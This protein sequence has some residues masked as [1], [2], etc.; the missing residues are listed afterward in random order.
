MRYELLMTDGD[1]P[2]PIRGSL[3][4]DLIFPPEQHVPLT[5]ETGD[6]ISWFY[7]CGKPSKVSEDGEADEGYF[8]ESRLPYRF[9]ADFPYIYAAFRELYGIDLITADYLHWWTFKALFCALHDCKFTEI[10]SCRTTETGEMSETM[11]KH[12]TKMQE[13]Y[14]LPVSMTERLRIARAQHFLNG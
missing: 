2:D 9:D 5:K 6:F 8:L 7:R 10:V 12:Y 1:V 3:A 13:I 4:A 11:K 14:E